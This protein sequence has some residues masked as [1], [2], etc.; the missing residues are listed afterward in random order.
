MLSATAPQA[1]DA[2]VGKVLR[3]EA[4]R[5]PA[6]QAAAGARAD[7][8][9]FAVGFRNPQ[10]LVVQPDTGELWVSEAGAG[11][12]ELTRVVTGGNGGWDPGCPDAPRSYCGVADPKRNRPLAAIT[13]LGKYPKALTP[14]WTNLNRAQAM[15]GVATL[16]GVQ[17][18]QWDGGMVVTYMGAPRVDVLKLDAGGSLSVLPALLEGMPVNFRA[19]AQ[20]PDGDLYLLTHGMAR[21]DQLWRRS[22]G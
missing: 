1:P 19:A 2:L 10:G 6:Q 18:R 20:G 16:R 7:Q 3:I 15:A 12:D 13:D 17:W 9:V 5:R 4:T 14:S 22:P 8:P 11:R 21:G